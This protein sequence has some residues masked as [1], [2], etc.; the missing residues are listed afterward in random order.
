MYLDAAYVAKFYLAEPDAI[1]VRAILRRAHVLSTSAW[2]LAEVTC[3][4]HRHLRQK[5][6]DA[7]LYRDLLRAF[8]EH[9]EG[10]LWTLVP[11]STGVLARMQT[12]FEEPPPDVHLRAG[13]AVHLASAVE[14]GEREVWTSDRNLLSAAPHFG[15][16]GRSA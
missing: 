9:T 8:R 2:S 1:K 16:V 10:G 6:L 3:A 5:D 14:V 4:F 12:Y 13:D 15:L 7:L 11:V